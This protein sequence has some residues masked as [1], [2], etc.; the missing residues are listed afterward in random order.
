M[1]Y[2][3]FVSKQS[4]IAECKIHGVKVNDIYLNGVSPALGITY[5]GTSKDWHYW[6]FSFTFSAAISKS[7]EVKRS[8]IAL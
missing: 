1:I 2:L 6:V 7:L 4:F 8:L 3:T 5:T